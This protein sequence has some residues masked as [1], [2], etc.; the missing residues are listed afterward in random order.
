M[1]QRNRYRKAY[2]IAELLMEAGVTV[3]QAEAASDET[4]AICGEAARMIL[5]TQKATPPSEETWALTVQQLRHL[6]DER[7]RHP[8]PFAGLYAVEPR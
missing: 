8:D 3:E 6:W 2:C 7:N 4:K 5:K 1:E